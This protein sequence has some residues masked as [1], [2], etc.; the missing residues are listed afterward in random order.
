MV[1]SDWHRAQL[2]DGGARGLGSL[3][4]QLGEDLGGVLTELRGEGSGPPAVHGEIRRCGQHGR[5]PVLLGHLD[6]APGGRELGIVDQLVDRLD[7]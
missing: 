5:G 2:N 4:V 6:Q 3:A 1:S 7:R